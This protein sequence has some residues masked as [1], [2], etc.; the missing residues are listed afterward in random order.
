MSQAQ[1]EIQLVAVLTACA[2]AIPGVFLVLRRMSLMSDAISHSILLG[3]VLGFFVAGDLASPVL[4]IGATLTGLLTVSLVELLTGTKLLK[5]DASMGIVFPLLFSIGVILVA[6]NAGNVHLDVDSIL[7][8]EI[9]FT[10]LNRL[11]MHG[12]DY[13]PK[14]AWLIGGILTMSLVFILL[15][16]KE[17]KL[18]TFDKSLAASLGFMPVLL[19]YGLMAIVSVTCVG[20][21]EA[22]GSI[23]VV[24]M[25]VTPPATAYLLTDKL[26]FMIWLSAGIG[27]MSAVAGYWVAH[28]LD[29]SI[30]GCMAGMTGAGFLLAMLFAPKRG[31]VQ[32]AKR[33]RHQKWDFAS[34]LL[35]VHLLNHEMAPEDTFERE[36]A[37]LEE[38]FEWEREWA[39]KV[40]RYSLRNRYIEVRNEQMFLTVN[41]RAIAVDAV[42]GR[43]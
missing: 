4:V 42:V 38:H 11:I 26:K 3:I 34:R 16:Y 36:M 43:I 18:S 39:D 7:L 24:A 6:R 27:A 14:A 9:A 17:L 8:G 35:L 33:L 23:L 19:H 1:A 21:F 25:I 31:I 41:G 37:Q 20:A 40:V 15:F 12:Y 28:S 13:G 2:C 32:V 5:Q 10:P 22:V 29:A 30:A